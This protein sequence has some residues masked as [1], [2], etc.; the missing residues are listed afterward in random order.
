MSKEAKLFCRRFHLLCLSTPPPG[1]QVGE[2]RV[3]LAPQKEVSVVPQGTGH[4]CGV[5]V[6]SKP[7]RVRVSR[8]FGVRWRFPSYGHSP[9]TTLG[10]S[11]P[12]VIAIQRTLTI[13]RSECSW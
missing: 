1:G 3:L 4:S 2:E 10:L 9:S 7:A 5:D 11:P 8:T 13:Q 6:V 12:E